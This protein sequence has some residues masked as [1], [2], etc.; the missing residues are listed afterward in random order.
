[1]GI[2]G[3]KSLPIT[4]YG[5][6]P[7]L[8]A[9]AKGW[10]CISQDC[11]FS[12]HG[13]VRRWPKACIQCGGPTDPLLDD[14]WSHEAEGV[15]LEWILKN[16]PERGGGFHRDQWEVWQFKDAVFRDD[17]IGMSQARTRARAYATQKLAEESW[18]SPGHVFFQFVWCGLDAGDLEGSA[19]D[20]CYW[21]SVS[22]NENVEQNN[23]NRT[24]CRQVIDMTGR[25]LKAP[26]GATHPRIPEIRQACLKLA[27]GA[28]PVL[29][30]EL[31]EVVLTLAR[32]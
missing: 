23:T 19:D 20:L 29:N 12:E 25:F 7:P 18:W 32:A 1:M 15:E 5:Y 31:Q 17:R 14:P 4:S 27:E 22:S 26:G 10:G 2:F 16:D 24:N 21:L 11:G 6:Q 28:Y 9:T 3:P 30:Q 8:S 13:Y